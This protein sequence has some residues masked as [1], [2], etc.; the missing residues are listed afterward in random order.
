MS[1]RDADVIAIGQNEY[2]K[3]L[4]EIDDSKFRV[5]EFRVKE[6]DSLDNVYNKINEL[7]QKAQKKW[8]N[9]LPLDMLLICVLKC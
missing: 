3:T 1:S 4:N 2:N 8:A 7:F 5:L 6:Q 9:T